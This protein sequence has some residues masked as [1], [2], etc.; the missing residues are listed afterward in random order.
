MFKRVI[1]EDWMQW[2]PVAATG[3]IILIFLAGSLWALRLSRRRVEHLSRL[4][5]EEGSPR[6]ND[7]PS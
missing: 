5:L 1:Y 2:V 3:V 7:S 6:H 4:P